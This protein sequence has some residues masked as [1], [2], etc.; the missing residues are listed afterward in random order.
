M[1][2]GRLIVSLMEKM[3]GN[4][5]I[6][7]SIVIPARNEANNIGLCLEAIYNQETPYSVEIIVIDS[8]STDNTVE[9]V[10]HYTSVKLIQIKP[11][12]FGHG[13]TRNQG[14]ETAKGTYIVF[15]NADALP[16][17]SLWLNRLIEPLEKNKKLAGVFSRHIPKQDCY[18]YM[19]RDLETSMPLKKILRSRSDIGGFFLFSTV[20]AAIP[21]EIW[22]QFPFENDI[23]IAEDQDWAKKVLAH[24]LE[25]LYEPTSAV[26]HSHNYTPRELMENKRKIARASKRF[27]HR[28][29]ALTIGFVLIV[30]GVFFKLSGDLVYIFFKSAKGFSFSQKI[31]EMKTAILARFASFRGRYEGWLS[32]E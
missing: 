21:K 32:N 26:R 10:K 29:G 24:G 7:V 17:D 3:S 5:N 19:K 6:T 28:F 11:G 15:L 2:D 18:L 9:I 14:A 23:I 22:T 20:S 1:K 27:K 4:T 12:A 16:I 13:R 30:G 8:G 31:K 25:I